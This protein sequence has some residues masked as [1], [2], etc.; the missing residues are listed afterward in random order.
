M[1]MDVVKF[2]LIVIV[3]G[4][5]AVFLPK[6]ILLLRVKNISETRRKGMSRDFVMAMIVFVAMTII[7][8]FLI[9][10]NSTIIDKSNGESGIHSGNMA[11]ALFYGL[12]KN[13]ERLDPLYCYFATLLQMIA[14]AVFGMIAAKELYNA[15]I[16]R[17]VAQ[18]YAFLWSFLLIN[19]C[20]IAYLYFK[21]FGF[22]KIIE[23]PS[24]FERGL[25]IFSMASSIVAYWIVVVYKSCKSL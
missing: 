16:S 6:R 10:H 11:A 12:L 22:L 1:D 20:S 7:T 19:L 4:W 24:S 18:T 17:N 15:L 8:S 2:L 5:I 14:G 23:Y 3:A 21:F 9:H 13:V 25:A